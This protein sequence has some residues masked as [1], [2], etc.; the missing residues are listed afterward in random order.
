VPR[1][2][3]A[4][5]LDA[6]RQLVDLLPVGDFSVTLVHD[7]A[8]LS[9][10]V[11]LGEPAPLVLAAL[12]TT[13]GDEPWAIP[14]L[15]S[16]RVMWIAWNRLDRSAA[17]V[18]AYE[19]GALAV[20]PGGVTREAVDSALRTAFARVQGT[21]HSGRPARHGPNR[22]PAN[23]EILIDEHDVLILES[24]IVSTSVL[25]DDG[26][27]VLIGM[28]GGGEVLVGHPHD[29][30]CLLWRAHTE[31]RGTVQ[32]WQHAAAT[33]A[34]ASRLRERIRRTDAWAAVV[35]RPHL[36]DRVIGLLSLLAEAFGSPVA[37]GVRLNLRLTHGQLASAIGA[38][39]AT[40]TRVIG[41]LRRQQT[42]DRIGEGHDERFVL[43]VIEPHSHR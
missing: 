23:S 1:L 20:L 41:R 34:F 5:P 43:R 17:A 42:L 29:S 9:A 36:E 16:R 26:S 14:L 2:L 25:H 33:P 11:N 24:G 21:A 28:A 32:S 13:S 12:E 37:T 27:E 4:G 35:A 40:V 15:E 7:A 19:L 39:R 30:C 3:L 22:Y 10:A 6:T 8:A 18:R 38:T 31:T